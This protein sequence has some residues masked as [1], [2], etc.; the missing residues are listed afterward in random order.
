MT[1]DTTPADARTDWLDVD[2][3][4]LRAAAGAS[5][6]VVFTHTAGA[7]RDF[8][9]SALQ[10]LANRLPAPWVV[11]ND[12]ALPRLSPPRPNLRDQFDDGAAAL[13]A[14]YERC[15]SVRLYHVN[16]F[17]DPGSLVRDVLDQVGDTLGDHGGGQV[18]RDSSLFCGSAGSTVPI[19]GDRH[20]NLLLQITGTK[21]I[22]VWWFAD[23]R[24][25]L[26]VLERNAG[27]HLNL[28]VVP[29]EHR[30]YE[31][32]PGEGLYL[33]PYTIHSVVCGPEP[34]TALS[35]SFSTVVS[36]RADRV[37]VA[38]RHLRRFRVDPRGPGDSVVVDKV[39]A[40]AVDG[41]R[42]AKRW[43]GRATVR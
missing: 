9:P 27:H 32:G 33:P 29:D 20:D 35:A 26:A 22:T 38:N 43:R 4:A 23:R 11:V 21:T 15:L 3:G 7:Y 25:E 12:G 18:R 10:D 28:E 17:P 8:E 30:V 39:K 1:L 5:R 6:A 34:S 13:R 16:H 42:R 40:A 31:L 24:R 19:H 14:L 36:E 41:V 37:H 2:A